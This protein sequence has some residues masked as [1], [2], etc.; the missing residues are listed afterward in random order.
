M[1]GYT[2][3]FVICAGNTDRQT[4]R[5]TTPSTGPEEGAGILPRRVEGLPSALGAMDYLDV[6]VHVFTPETRALL[7]ARAALGDV[8]RA[9]YEPGQPELEQI[10]ASG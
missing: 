5:S 1:L 3:F 4:R 7:R 6:V 8:P 2:D 10:A 9:A